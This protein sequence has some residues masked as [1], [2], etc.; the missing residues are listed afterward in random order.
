MQ[1]I[2]RE[3]LDV[4]LWFIEQRLEEDENLH[5]VAWCRFRAE[6]FRMMV[7]VAKRFPQ[8]ECGAIHGSQQK[9]LRLKAL[10]LLKPETSPTGPVFVGGIEGTGSFGIDLSAAHTCV[11]M[12]SG[13]SPGR[14]SQTLDRVVGPTQTHP[15]AYYDIVAVGPKGQATIDRDILIARRSGED[16]A[17]RTSAAWVRALTEE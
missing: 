9:P 5:L 10:S 2:G 6:L 12:S 8:F 1:D 7:E 17:Q 3:K 14:S 16:I 15:I 4:L 13:Y 11:T